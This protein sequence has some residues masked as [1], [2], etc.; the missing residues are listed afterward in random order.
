MVQLLSSLKRAIATLQRDITTAVS[1]SPSNLCRLS[2]IHTAYADATQ[3]DSC[4]ASAVCIGHNSVILKITQKTAIGL[5]YCRWAQKLQ[6]QNYS[7]RTGHGLNERRTPSQTM[8]SLHLGL[9]SRYSRYI[10]ALSSDERRQNVRYYYVSLRGYDSQ[11]FKCMY[12]LRGVRPTSLY[13]PKAK[14]TVNLTQ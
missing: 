3:L 14:L 10:V 12:Q 1:I 4:V 13:R 11:E 2:P 6:L 8:S 7:V 5:H 9:A